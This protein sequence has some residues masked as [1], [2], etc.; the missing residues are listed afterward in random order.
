MKGSRQIANSSFDSSIV[1]TQQ[2]EHVKISRRDQV[3][4][5]DSYLPY[6]SDLWWTKQELELTRHEQ[7]DYSN[8]SHQ[9]LKSLGSF[10]N[11]YYFLRDELHVAECSQVSDAV[12]EKKT[13]DSCGFISIKAYNKLIKG[14]HKE[15]NGIERYIGH[16]CE[17]RRCHVLDVTKQ[18]VE[19]YKIQYDSNTSNEIYKLVDE[20]I[21]ASYT[22]L[23]T[24]KDRY[25]SNMIG[26]AQH[27]AAADSKIN[28]R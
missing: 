5:I 24:T 10:L 28:K 25:W 7:L 6:A 3:K 15:F 19:F 14:F 16:Y 21:V 1:C 11:S 27:L 18:V 26:Y 2:L 13:V 8:A 4:Y 17:V 20:E 22:R 23:L 12:K 9:S